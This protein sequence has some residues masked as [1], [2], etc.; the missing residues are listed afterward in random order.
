MPRFQT[1]VFSR[2]IQRMHIVSV[3]YT[4]IQKKIKNVCNIQK[5]MTKKAKIYYFS[6]TDEMRKE[7]KLD[8]FKNAKLNKIPFELI[9]PDPKHNW[10]NLTDN[11]FEDLIP[12]VD[13]KHK[14][15]I[16]EFY[17]N[18]VNTARDEWVYDFDR[19]NLDSKMQYFI[20]EY[21]TL[22]AKNDASWK[23]TIKW[24]EALKNYFKRRIKLQ[25]DGKLI[26]E[27]N[28]RPFI[29]QFYYAE[30]FLSDRLTQNHYDMFGKDLTK[31][32]ELIG[33]LSGT[34]LDFGIY[35]TNLIPNF[36]SFSLDPARWLPLYRYTSQGQ[37]LDNITDWALKLFQ[38]KYPKLK[39]VPPSG[40]RGLIF[41]YVYG[42]LHNPA[43]RSKYE[44]NLKRDFPRIPLYTDFEF[45]AAQ[46]KVLMELHLK[47][48]SIAPYP[49][50]RIES[51]L[52]SS[53]LNK[54][55]LRADKAQG[56]I[57]LDEMTRL[58]GVPAL[59]WEYKLGNRCALEWILDQYKEKKPTDPTI[60]AKFN[61]YR[62]ED[63]KE[64]VID[65]LQRVCTVSVKTMEVIGEMEG[66]SK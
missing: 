61:T 64:Q 38:E 42:V 23:E 46:G 62:F 30:K 16:F 36:A 44:Q 8:W 33:Y 60:A 3:S 66:K 51:E 15:T 19:D 57:T 47:Y 9:T 27:G 50:Q 6:L 43:Y 11:D 53:S 48:E 4:N 49:L 41:H 7:E 1:E 22:L 12:L 29:K 5:T 54:A 52:K 32:N 59:A 13:K 31:K 18:G 2:P 39:E 40:V 17:S 55:K 35:V 21:N 63:Y 20:K 56:I 45:W 24:S 34:R 26:L 65:L 10:L 37:K 14:N 25:F 28:Y 58:E